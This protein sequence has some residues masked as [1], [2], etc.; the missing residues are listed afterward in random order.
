MRSSNR[1]SVQRCSDYQGSG[2]AKKNPTLCWGGL[3]LITPCVTPIPR[4][5]AVTK[6]TANL[7]HQI[8][9]WCGGGVWSVFALLYSAKETALQV[10]RKKVIPVEVSLFFCD[11]F[12]IILALRIR[13]CRCGRRPCSFFMLVFFLYFCARAFLP[14]LFLSSFANAHLKKNR[15]GRGGPT[16]RTSLAP[17]SSSGAWCS[18]YVCFFF[19]G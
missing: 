11:H 1:H 13:T 7:A 9:D 2:F 19:W 8:T 6:Q 5:S 17:C 4:T 12:Q 16:K 10:V 15:G 14:L 18:V 3:C